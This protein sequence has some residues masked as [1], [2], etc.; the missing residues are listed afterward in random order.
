MKKLLFFAIVLILSCGQA[1]PV[2]NLA[3][4]PTRPPAATADKLLGSVS[5]LMWFFENEHQ[6]KCRV[7][8]DHWRCLAPGGLVKI[9]FFNDPVS[10]ATISIPLD[11]SA[12][13]PSKYVVSLLH[14]TG[15]DN[16]AW[17]WLVSQ[18]EEPEMSKN[19]GDR[20]L[21]TQMDTESWLV[22]VEAV[23]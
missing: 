20:R 18:M 3:P 2:A 8:G 14:Q 7:S 4:Q 12:G 17:D 11:A 5:S 1:A 19:F 16:A 9:T 6:F 10:E 15:L 21:T 22:T 13:K 23:R